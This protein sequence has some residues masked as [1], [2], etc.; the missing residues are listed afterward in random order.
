MRKKLLI[1]VSA[2][3]ACLLS[4]Q[5]QCGKEIPCE[6]PDQTFFYF[7]LT[8]AHGAGLIGKPG[9]KYLSDSTFLVKQDGTPANQLVRQPNGD[10]FFYLPD[11]PENALDSTIE[12]LYY[13]HLPDSA[14]RP[15]ADT[16]TL[17]IAYKMSVVEGT[18]CFDYLKL[19]FNG[20]TYY[21]GPFVDGVEIVKK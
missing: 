13:L 14:G 15:Y 19:A 18:T 2:V 4:W 9:S 17:T 10:L 1:S 3:A 20:D 11:P 8:D 6:F 21:D 16:D 7:R 12:K 5:L